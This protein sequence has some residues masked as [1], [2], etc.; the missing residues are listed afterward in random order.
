MIIHVMSDGTV[1]ESVEGLKI[2]NEQFYQILHDIQKK[3]R[4]KGATQK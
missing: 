2:H 1:R 3:Y 4:K